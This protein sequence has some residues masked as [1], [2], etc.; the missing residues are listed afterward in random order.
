MTICVESA[1]S[2]EARPPPRSRPSRRRAAIG[3]LMTA[4][5]TQVSA[6][7]CIERSM[8][9]QQ[10]PV[11]LGGVG[12]RV[13]ASAA[14]SAGNRAA[15][16]RARLRRRDRVA[17]DAACEDRLVAIVNP[18]LPCRA[19]DASFAHAT[20]PLKSLVA[21]ERRS[22]CHRSA[23]RTAVPPGGDSGRRCRISSCVRAALRR[24]G[25]CRAR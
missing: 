10:Q 2:R 16:A 14:R 4:A 21:G 25:L 3:P 6:G 12:P 23:R 20:C 17:H 18:A 1:S 11:P 7:N 22:D 15:A 9:H 5:I 8:H 13:A 19:S 24:S